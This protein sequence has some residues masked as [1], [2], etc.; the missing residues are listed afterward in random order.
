MKRG[1]WNPSSLRSFGRFLRRALSK[2]MRASSNIE[3]LLF[4]KSMVR[5]HHPANENDRPD[6]LSFSLVGVDG[7]EPS[8]KWL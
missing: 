5:F 7:I 6:G 8:T 3:P 4:H 2:L 1:G